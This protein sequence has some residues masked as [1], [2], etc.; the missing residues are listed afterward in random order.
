MSDSS[1]TN[2]PASPPRRSRAARARD[3]KI[4]GVLALII[5]IELGL[6][7]WS[8]IPIQE[9]ALH[10]RD[11]RYE[12]SASVLGRNDWVPLRRHDREWIRTAAHLALE[13]EPE[14]SVSRVREQGRR[15]IVPLRRS[16]VLEA[17][18]RRGL[19]SAALAWE[20][21]ARE[22]RDPGER[23]LLLKA[24][25]LVGDGRL[26]EAERALAA[27]PVSE[28]SREGLDA[29]RRSITDQTRGIVPVVLDR[30]GKVLALWRFADDAIVVTEPSAAPLIAALQAQELR[31]PWPTLHM[32][33][34]VDR[35]RLLEQ[36]LEGY[37]GTIAAVE[38]ATGRVLGIVATTGVNPLDS[39][40]LGSLGRLAIPAAAGAYPVVCNGLL[41]VERGV[42]LDS[43]RHGAVPDHE[44]ALTWGCS[45][46]AGRSAIEAGRDAVLRSVSDLGFSSEAA[47]DLELASIP[48]ADGTVAAT[49]LDLAA[50]AG[51][52]GSDGVRRRPVLVERRTSILGEPLE[53]TPNQVNML[54]AQTSGRL[55]EVLRRSVLESRGDAHLLAIEGIDAGAAGGH[56]SGADGQFSARMIGFSPLRA[57]TLAVAVTLEGS[58]PS[59]TSAARLMAL[60]LDR[61]RIEQPPTDEALP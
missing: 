17:L 49:P 22:W 42:V 13:R 57:P 11:G 23:E 25:A 24:A 45:V 33:L 19:F 5:A 34:D 59:R 58:G 37:R 14:Q 53:I 21:A 3:L 40:S 26:E 35:Q 41:R 36:L 50:L 1:A 9:A 54:E 51:A 39:V 10:F 28:Q 27:V 43:G 52:L 18:V 56:Y 61:V 12:A 60:I 29:L 47:S 2:D 16:E 44:A 55:R 48:S 32:T 30:D 20:G 6:W 4:A 15:F 8:G 38:P 31:S 7:F 46:A